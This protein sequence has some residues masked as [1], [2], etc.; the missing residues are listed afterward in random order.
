MKKSSYVGLVTM[1]GALASPGLAWA[2]GTCD[3]NTKD[4]LPCYEEAQRCYGDGD[5]Q[6]AY[7][8]YRRAF[9]LRPS[10]DTAGNLG[11][12]ALKLGRYPEAVKYL[13]YALA[14]LPVSGQ[15]D[16]VEALLQ[17][18][19]G[20][21]AKVTINVEP[22]GAAV[23]L[24]G[25][26]L[27]HAPL[28][29]EVVVDRGQHTLRLSAD[30]HCDKRIE[31]DLAAGVRDTQHVVLQP[32]GPG[33]APPPADSEGPGAG[34]VAAVVSSSVAALGLMGAGIG[35]HVLAM[36]KGSD[37]E[38][39]AAD[40]PSDACAGS[41]PSAGCADLQRLADEQR[42]AATTGTV[43]LA[44]GGAV[45]LGTTLTAIFTYPDADGGD[46][47]ALRAVPMV[48][49]GVGGLVLSGQF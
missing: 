38:A 30:G 29:D 8:A 11:N 37:R 45:A 42:T 41:D 28:A 17:Q 33:Q 44:I 43:L 7:D 20:Q 40:L 49:P 34:Y 32:C 5:L 15:A 3:D 16:R 46:E 24:D 19:E 10:Y 48:G 47:L 2:E 23:E 12:T 18:A 1:L 22:A 36:G 21:V 13:R 6:C 39:V 14:N 9:D 31:L 25:K 4:P 35:M 26:L 27:G